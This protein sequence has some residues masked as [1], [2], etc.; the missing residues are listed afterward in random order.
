M[1]LCSVLCGSLDGRWGWGRATCMCQSLSRVQLL[2]PHT[3]WPTRFLYPWTSL[4]K[5]IGVGSPPFSRGSSQPRD[6]TRVSCT[7]GVFFTLWATR[8]AWRGEWRH[9]Y[10]G[11]SPFVV[12][13]KLTTLLTGYSPIQN[14]KFKRK[15]KISTSHFKPYTRYTAILLKWWIEI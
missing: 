11:L 4:G 1:E 8:E 12:C 10:V 14:K 13:L 6:W 15:K 5:N 9:V 2:Q 3:L 7:A